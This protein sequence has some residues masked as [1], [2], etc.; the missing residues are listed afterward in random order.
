V[1]RSTE[2]TLTLTIPRYVW[3]V[4]P[5]FP[6]R[7]LCSKLDSAP[8]DRY[9]SICWRRHNTVMSVPFDTRTRV[10]LLQH[11]SPLRGVQLYSNRW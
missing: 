2:A 5:E 10:S 9:T 4:C 11:G 1:D 6:V 7:I 3:V 8:I